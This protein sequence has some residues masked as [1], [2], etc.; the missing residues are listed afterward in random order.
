MS[1]DEMLSYMYSKLPMLKFVYST[2]NQRM[3]M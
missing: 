3:M 2:M 1:D